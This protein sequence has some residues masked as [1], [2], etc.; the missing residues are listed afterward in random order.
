[1]VTREYL[2]AW[3]TLRYLIYGFIYLY[4]SRQQSTS[5]PEIDTS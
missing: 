4:L 2:V 1:M 3:L 5:A